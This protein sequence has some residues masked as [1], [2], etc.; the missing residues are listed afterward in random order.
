MTIPLRF[1]IFPRLGFQT[2]LWSPHHITPK[3]AEKMS[4]A[5]RRFPV[6]R[7]SAV[8]TVESS[9]RASMAIRQVLHRSWHHPHSFRL[10]PCRC[11]E[12]LGI[13]NCYEMLSECLVTILLYLWCLFWRGRV[14]DMVHNFL[15]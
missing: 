6:G 14:V 11:L 10:H 9:G 7:I 1:M 15:M 5:F 4:R 8:P 13:R 12:D 2:S 3:N